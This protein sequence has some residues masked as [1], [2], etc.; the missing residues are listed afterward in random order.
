MT[1]MFNRRR[2]TA[3]WILAVIF[4]IIIYYEFVV[5]MMAPFF[6]HH[7]NCSSNKTVCTKVLIVADA[8]I[9]GENAIGPPLR[10][11]LNWD[12][13]RYLGMTYENAV[14]FFKPH[15]VIFLGDNMDEGSVATEEQYMKYAERLKTIFSTDVPLL[16]IWIPGDN[17]IGGED[18]PVYKEKLK[19]FKSTFYQPDVISHG[20]LD[21]YKVNR[22]TWTLPSIPTG[23]I[24]SRD[25]VNVVISHMPIIGNGLFAEKVRSQLHPKIILS[26]HDHLSKYIKMNSED[27]ISKISP[28][29]PESSNLEINL[30]DNG[31]HEIQVPTCSYRMGVYNM[32]YGAAVFDN[33]GQVMRYNV[34]WS[35]GR[36]TGLI[37]YA[38]IL[39]SCFTYLLFFFICKYYKTHLC[40][41]HKYAKL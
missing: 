35:P 11:L 22:I 27:T 30:T 19:L 23:H 12:S 20:E 5:F 7:L 13:D 14:L 21:F 29:G 17:D 33:N 38:I 41:G 9:L 2:F 26:G 25:K 10:Y 15:I 1:Q 4:S 32:G 18:E 28:F 31:Y 8:Q 34:L 3:K 24:I 39:V 6:W 16:E 37:L 40:N 36:F